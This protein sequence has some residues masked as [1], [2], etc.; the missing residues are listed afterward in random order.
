MQEA[1]ECGSKQNKKPFEPNKQLSFMDWIQVQQF[2]QKIY[3]H[4]TEYFF[5][6][7]YRS[8]TAQ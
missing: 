3:K 8:Y 4:N 5:D 1:A 7:G 2:I 6:G